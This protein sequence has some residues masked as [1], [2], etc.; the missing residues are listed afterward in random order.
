MLL[1]AAPVGDE[2]DQ[3]GGAVWPRLQRPR[4]Q[5]VRRQRGQ[6]ADA[7]ALDDVPDAG[8]M[9]LSVGHAGAM[10]DAVRCSNVLQSFQARDPLKLAWREIS[11]LDASCSAQPYRNYEFR[12]GAY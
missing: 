11:G 5:A 10:R 3:A 8:E 4:P 1:A 9:I 12:L 7:G 2:P 6:H